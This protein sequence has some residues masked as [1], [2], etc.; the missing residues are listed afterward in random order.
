VNLKPGLRLSSQVCDAEVVV[1]KGSGDHE[2]GCGGSPT[3]PV[4]DP[5][6]HQG[7][8]SEELADGTLMGKRYTDADGTVEILCTK[9]GQGTLTFDG[10]V[11]TL[12][13]TKALPSSD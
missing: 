1:I 13:E 3:V 7:T 6:A 12:K 8:V 4:G 2:L 9:P 11:L 5:G 10:Q